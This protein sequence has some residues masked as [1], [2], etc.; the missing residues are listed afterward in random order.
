MGKNFEM[1]NSRVDLLYDIYYQRKH[2]LEYQSN[3]PGILTTEFTIHPRYPMKMP[4]E[5]LFKLINSNTMV[6]MV[7]YNPGR[8]RENIYRLYAANT[9]TNGKKIPYLFTT[10]DNKKGKIIR[11]SRLLARKKRVAYYIEYFKDSINYAIDCEFEING[12][13]NI[14]V[15]H[16]AIV[17][18]EELEDAIKNAINPNILEKV[19]RFLEQSG[20]TFQVFESFDQDNIEFKDITLISLLEI[21]KNIK[22]KNFTT[23][24][25]SVFTLIDDSLSAQQDE[26]RLKYK[27]VSNYNELDSIESFINEMRR[28]DE[29]PRYYYT[30]TLSK[31]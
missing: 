11:L 15:K 28:N 5:M 25:S 22:L 1:Y 30:K 23:C 31:L 24:L 6:P 27:R 13:V 21:K 26:L 2:D 16:S 18:K 4:L 7:K 12:N 3:T 9:A 20:Y 8:D 14:T 29:A 17:K 10:N 19:Q